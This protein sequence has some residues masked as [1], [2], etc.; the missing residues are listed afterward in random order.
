M[1]SGTEEPQYREHPLA[2]LPEFRITVSGADALPVVPLA[3][4]TSADDAPPSEA[5]KVLARATIHPTVNGAATTGCLAGSTA[6]IRGV[7]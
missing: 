5:T 3:S 4:P 1:L 7:G 2:N 6:G